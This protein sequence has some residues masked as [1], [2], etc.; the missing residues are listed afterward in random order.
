MVLGV[1][2]GLQQLAETCSVDTTKMKNI[3]S[4]PSKSAATY[5]LIPSHTTV[6]RRV[7]YNSH[8][9]VSLLISGSYSTPY[10]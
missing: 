5:L 7:K 4:I 8:G 1:P 2:I 3:T 6:E 9:P 10:T